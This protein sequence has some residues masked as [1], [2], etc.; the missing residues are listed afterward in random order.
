ME[1]RRKGYDPAHNDW[2]Y[3]MVNPDGTVGMSGT[4]QPDSATG[5][6]RRLP[7]RRQDE[8]LCLW[9][10]HDHE[11]QAHTDGRAGHESLRAEEPVRRGKEVARLAAGCQPRAL[12]ARL[13][14]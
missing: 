3:A 14:C 10:W 2:H 8:R 9:Q 6:L 5:L 4:G 13:P 11:G 1:K 7:Q 12:P